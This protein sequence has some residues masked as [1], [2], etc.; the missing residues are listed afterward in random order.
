M[1]DKLLDTERILTKGE[2][3]MDLL[4]QKMTDIPKDLPR[5]V[6]GTGNPTT[7]EAKPADAATTITQ[8]QGKKKLTEKRII[9]LP[10]KQTSQLRL[11]QP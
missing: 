3:M 4:E 2:I 10:R 8:T 1:E 9:R 11:F 7:S 5:A 6:E